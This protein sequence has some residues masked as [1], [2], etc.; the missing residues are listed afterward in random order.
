ML[1]EVEEKILTLPAANWRIRN[2]NENL[3]R[4]DSQKPSLGTYVSKTP[5]LLHQKLCR[6]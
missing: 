6:Y 2:K 5:K 4:K 3:I 1:E